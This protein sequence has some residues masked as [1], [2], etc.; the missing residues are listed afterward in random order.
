MTSAN[1]LA[2]EANASMFPGLTLPRDWS[3]YSNTSVQMEQNLI[4]QG[5]AYSC[6]LVHIHPNSRP[7]DF[8]WKIYENRGAQGG[9]PLPQP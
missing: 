8:K 4:E 1:I 7:N 9:G 2:L 3:C 6:I 5:I